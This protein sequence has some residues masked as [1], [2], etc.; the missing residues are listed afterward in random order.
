MLHRSLAAH[1]LAPRSSHLQLACPL[2]HSCQSTYHLPQHPAHTHI[3]PH[4]AAA[5]LTSTLPAWSCRHSLHAIASQLSPAHGCTGIELL[6]AE[7]F[8]LHCFQTLTGT[9]FLLVVEP[10]MPYVPMILQKCVPLVVA[11]WLHAAWAAAAVL[12]DLECRGNG[13]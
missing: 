13:R 9:K 4:N 10:Q 1:H 11:V 12:C 6:E 3:H 2:M 8:D 7:T 5:T